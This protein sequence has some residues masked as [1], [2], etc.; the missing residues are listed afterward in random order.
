ML[1][2][3]PEDEDPVPPY[4]H[5]GHQL[6]VKFFGMG[7][8][9]VNFQFD[10]NIP[11]PMGGIN[12]EENIAN[13]EDDGWDAWLVQQVQTPKPVVNANNMEEQFS[14]QHSGLEDLPSHESVGFFNDII[15]PQGIQFPHVEAPE[16][17]DAVLAL[18]AFPPEGMLLEGN[19]DQ[20]EENMQ[21]E[22]NINVGVTPGFR[23]TKTR[24]QT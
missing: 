22:E 23:G 3:Q 11:P 9:V 20:G 8:L 14:Y 10:L 15:I 2:A 16:P 18:P 4:P 21:I 7:Q 1:G 6:P 13:N 24:A 12:E 5:D 17:A 19:N